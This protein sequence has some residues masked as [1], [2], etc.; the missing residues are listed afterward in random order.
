MKKLL[1]LI[2]VFVFTFSNA[3][4]AMNSAVGYAPDFTVSDI[5]GVSHTLYNYLDSGYVMV[6]ELMS[7]SC[8]HCIQ[9][10]AGTENS[11][12]TNGPS[13]SNA[14]RFL[15]LEVNASTNN[16]AI[17]NFA[18]TYGAS[19]PIAN[20]ISPSGIGYMLY[21]TPTYYVVYPDRSYTTI[22]GYNCVTANSS[23]TIESKLNTAIAYWPPTLGCTDPIALNYNSLANLD[24]GSCDYSSYTIET[25]GMSFIPDTVICDVGDTI[26]FI[27]GAGHNA[28]EVSDST[29]IIGGNTALSGGF[30]FGYGSTGYF[31]PDDCHHFY[32]VCQPHAQLGMKGV[33]I[34]HHPP[35]FGCTDSTAFNYDSTAT[36]DDGSCIILGCTGP[37][38]CNYNPVANMD[39]GSCWGWAGCTDSTAI[40]Y[41]AMA[42]CDDG[43]CTYVSC[44]SI[45]GIY[46]SDIIHKRAIFN[47]DNMNSSTCQVD[48]IRIRYREVGTISWLTKTMGAPVGSGCNTTNTSKLVRFLI[49]STQYEYEFKIWYC[50]SSTVSWHSYGTFTTAPD[51]DNA[52]NV[53]ATPL[54]TTKTEFCWDSVTTY[55]FVR[56]KYR[57]DVPGSTFSSIGGFGVLSPTLCKTK[58]GLTPGLNYRVKWKTYCSP[59]G[60]PYRGP[61]WDGPVLWTQPTSVRVE[62]TDIEER[63]LIRITDIL[64]RE[65]NPDKVIDKTTLLYIYDDGTVEKKIILE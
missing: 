35:V 32:Y 37:T 38:Y 26:N 48:Q 58:N 53:T 22:C 29:W 19:F 13:G 56:L 61:Q 54:N 23:S 52:I 6:L 12:I 10:A 45:T 17:S 43:S 16:T 41:N 24:D 1:L 47:W 4:T 28:V 46:M 39:D 51:C 64:G 40:N 60:G 27:L 5:N 25:V 55:S 14:A 20:N 62:N 44:G 65:V 30:N 2:S 7:V 8:G 9:H 36:V 11:Y 31:V 21:G 63:Q 18:N 3:Q 59:N 57:E 42:N 33:I 34:A 49:P 50:N 15:G